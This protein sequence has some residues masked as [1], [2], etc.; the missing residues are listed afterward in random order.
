MS[1]KKILVL[2]STFP[3]WKNDTNPSFVFDLSRRLVKSFE[4]TV[5][6]PHYARSKTLESMN[7]LKVYRFRYFISPLE[8]LAGSGG[9]LPTLKQNRLNY[10]LVPFFFIGETIGAIRII[11]KDHP[12]IIHAHWII[13]QGLI[14]LFMKKLFN[15]PYVVTSHGGDIFAL[16]GKLLN[17]IKLSILNNAKTITVVSFAIKNNVINLNHKLESKIKVIPMG[18]DSKLFNPNKYSKSLKNKYNPN[19]PILLFVGRL[20]E[21]K[22]VEY[23]IKAMP[24]IIKKDLK[25]KLLI[26]GSGTL[27]NKLKELANRLN[28]NKNII[29]I[30]P[31]PNSELPKYYATADIFIGPSIKIKNGDTEGLPV[32]FLEASASGCVPIGTNAGGI[33]EIIKHGESGIILK[34][35]N[36]LQIAVSVTKLLEDNKLRLN[37]SK[38]ARIFVKDNFDWSIISKKY[39]NIY[40]K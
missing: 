38:N 17:S 29:F 10:F 23:L 4:I 1:K 13:P 35:K 18:V 12:D 8:K 7:G 14:A 3:R 9:I 36:H 6:A 37:F 26:V 25:V 27:E 15:I 28:L 2:T 5:L 24:L 16:Q 20:A 32:T 11:L 30:G 34:Q 33:A 31:L 39:N 40:L 21:K 22:G 19:G